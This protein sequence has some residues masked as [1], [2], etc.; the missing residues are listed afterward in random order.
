M[1]GGLREWILEW[2]DSP[3]GPGALGVLSA[4]EAVFFPLPPDPL[5]IA[6]AL[7]HPSSALLLAALTTVAS[8]LGGLVGH[9]LGRRWGRPMLYRFHS[10]RVERVER[11][12]VRHGFWALVIA[13]LTPVPYKVFTISAGVFALPRSQFIMA[14]VL[15]RGL[16][17]FTIGVLIQLWGE[18][19]SAFLEE[20][21]DLV[22]AAM[23]AMAL[24]AA[25]VWWYWARRNGTLARRAAAVEVE[26][27]AIEPG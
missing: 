22:L 25:T 27:E 13:G 16:R 8:V 12:F 3:G 10:G 7:R 6:L 2:A 19:F 4:I 18:S 24:G 9:W 11:L 14:S 26:P 5:L 17:F 1:L 15:G 21:F 20:R 23:G